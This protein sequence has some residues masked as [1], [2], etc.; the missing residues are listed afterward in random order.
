MKI[1]YIS[2]KILTKYRISVTTEAKSVMEIRLRKKSMK[3]WKFRQYFADISVSDRN[4]GEI[5][6]VEHARLGD[7]LLQNIGD[8]SE[9]SIKYRRYIKNINKNIEDISGYIGDI[10]KWPDLKS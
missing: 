10:S 5:S 8:I 7:F 6:L 1:S 4:F 2:A 9:I 3:N